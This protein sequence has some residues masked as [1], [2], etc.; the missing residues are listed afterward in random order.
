MQPNLELSVELN[1]FTSF[2]IVL[3]G[4]AACEISS[5]SDHEDEVEECCDFTLLK[6]AASSCEEETLH[7]FLR[8]QHC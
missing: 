6:S 4:V 2:L 5:S 3:L 8:Q 1:L 7:F